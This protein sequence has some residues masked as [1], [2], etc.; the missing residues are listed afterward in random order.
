MEWFLRA[1]PSKPKP[2]WLRY[3]VTTLLVGL[4]FLLMKAVQEFT[5]IQGYFLLFPAIFLAA[6]AFDRGSGF[7]HGFEHGL[8]GSMGRPARAI[9]VQFR[10][11]GLSRS[12]CDD[13]SCFGRSQ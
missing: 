1:L 7:C 11:L 2:L 10:T 9:R 12:V 6:I 3:A 8:A 13:W 5:P 4:S